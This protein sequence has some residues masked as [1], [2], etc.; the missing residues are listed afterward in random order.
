[1]NALNRY[2][3]LS[4]LIGPK[5]KNIEKARQK[6]LE[7]ELEQLEKELAKLKPSFWDKIW[8]KINF[9]FEKFYKYTEC[10]L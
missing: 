6:R 4:A 9:I 7:K 8:L 3:K 1:M 5:Q 2:D 10:L